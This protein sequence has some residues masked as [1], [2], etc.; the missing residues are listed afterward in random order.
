MS[1]HLGTAT[2][3]TIIDDDDRRQTDDRDDKSKVPNVFR[4][5]RSCILNPRHTH[6]PAIQ[7]VR[8]RIKREASPV[9]GRRC[10]C[11]R[12]RYRCRKIS[13]FSAPHRK[14]QSFH[15]NASR[16]SHP[17]RW[18]TRRL[19]PLHKTITFSSTQ[20]A[21]SLPKNLA[22]SIR[23][24][25]HSLHSD[26]PAAPAAPDT[27]NAQEPALGPPMGRCSCRPCFHVRRCRPE[28]SCQRRPRSI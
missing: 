11:R 13:I 16:S 25:R 7:R 5:Q 14:Y 6:N 27:R 24:S 28:L 9:S 23:R 22:P 17:P 26:A 2:T 12:C 15:P 10:R 8:I 21:A 3:T 1:D 19:Y 18:S 20:L 4:R